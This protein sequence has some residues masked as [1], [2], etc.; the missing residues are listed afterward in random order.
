MSP[1]PPVLCLIRSF[2][3]KAVR[4]EESECENP[5][6]WEAP[7]KCSLLNPSPLPPSTWSRSCGRKGFLSWAVITV[8]IHC[9]FLPGQKLRNQGPGQSGHFERGVLE[10]P[11]AALCPKKTTFRK[12]TSVQHDVVN[13]VAFVFGVIEAER[14]AK[15]FGALLGNRR[16]PGFHVHSKSRSG[17]EVGERGD[18]CDKGSC[19]SHIPCWLPHYRA[20]VC[21]APA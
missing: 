2:L 9:D 4:A 12:V 18:E 1:H 17:R 19:H 10:M 8:V 7:E 11:P 6:R 16:M 3:S 20:S 5:S 13:H 21:D 15:I 14:T